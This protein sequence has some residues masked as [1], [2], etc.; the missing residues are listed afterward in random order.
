MKENSIGN[1]IQYLRNLLNLTKIDFCK[2]HNIPY[3]TYRSWE[4]NGKP[5][6]YKTIVQLVKLFNQAGIIVSEEW[7]I[8]GTGT[9]PY[10]M[11]PTK[12]DDSILQVH[13]FDH[14]D[15]YALMDAKNFQSNYTNSIIMLIYDDVMTP[16]FNPGDY[17][18][19]IYIPLSD[20]YKWI[21]ELCIVT[22]KDNSTVFRKLGVNATGEICLLGLNYLSK[23]PNVNIDKPK[24]KNIAPILYHR[25]SRK[26]K[27]I[28]IRHQ[29]KI[30]TSPL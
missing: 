11:S 18:G 12:L 23:E 19:G 27:I 25:I 4:K 30:H 28:S 2:L 17:I 15:I 22:L 24:I 21:G 29:E 9:E 16:S 8:A 26:N 5:L 20:I 13:S 1:R 3:S 14:D 7:L 10:K 6:K